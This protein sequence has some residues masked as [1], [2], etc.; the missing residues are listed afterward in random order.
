MDTLLQIPLFQGVS[1]DEMDWMLAHSHQEML[2]NGS[3]FFKESEPA[4]RFYIVLEG[5]LQVSRM[6]NGSEVIMGTTPRGVMGGEI[7]LLSQSPSQITARAIMPCR[8]LVFDEDAFRA[9]FA[10]CPTVGMRILETTAERMQGTVEIVKQREKMAALGKLS[11]GLAHELNNPAAAA[12]RASHALRDTLPA[13]QTHALT[14]SRLGLS[15]TQT[16]QL[17]AFQLTTAERAGHAAPLSPLEQ[18]DREDELST[19]L[20]RHGVT[21]GWALAETFVSAGLA[22]EDFAPLIDQFPADALVAV[23]AWLH[24]TL[25]AISLLDTIEQSTQRI[26]DLVAAIKSYTYRDQAPVQDVDIRQGLE[27][28]L[29]VLRHKLGDVHV[30]RQY[31]PA[32]P[33]VHARG[34]ELNQVWTNLIDNAIDAM[35]GQGML[36]IITR[37]EAEFV[38][39]EIADTGP[40]IPPDVLP[41]LFEPFFTTKPLGSGTGLGLDISYRII[42]QHNGTIEVRSEPGHTRFIVRLPLQGSPSPE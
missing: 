41:R 32:L 23:L 38:M 40:G 17:D 16:A 9:L 10:A 27:N 25:E 6:V 18:S 3:Y 8:L 5:E 4:G 21:D 13:L 42:Q 24:S 36:T 11:A 30:E 12:R 2:E 15:N 26:A 39:V 34:G 29:T 31:D 22:A 37:A 20:G 7:A 35:H 28:T 33:R 19:W 1:D 14:L